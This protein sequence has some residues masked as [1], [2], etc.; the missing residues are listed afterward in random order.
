MS[1]LN[2]GGRKSPSVSKKTRRA[3][4]ADVRRDARR[5]EAKERNDWYQ[6]QTA[7][8]KIDLLDRKLGKGVGAVKQRTRLQLQLKQEKNGQ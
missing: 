3:Q 4:F 1:E 5:A 2:F 8:Q 6:T 7:Q